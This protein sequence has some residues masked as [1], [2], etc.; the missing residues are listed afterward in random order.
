MF[1]VFIHVC[2]KI[3]DIHTAWTQAITVAKILKK[4][5]K[6]STLVYRD[7]QLSF[8]SFFISKK[9]TILKGI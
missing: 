5:L 4:I 1:D 8:Q 3:K 2:K 7:A 9:W 6:I